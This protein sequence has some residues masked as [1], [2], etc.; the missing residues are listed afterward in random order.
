VPASY[1]KRLVARQP[2]AR[3]LRPLRTVF[4][5]PAATSEP[6][7]RPVTATARSPAPAAAAPAT[8]H[9]AAPP[10]NAPRSERQAPAP[11]PLVAQ[12]LIRPE[13]VTLRPAATPRETT[14][15]P[16]RQARPVLFAPPAP[17]PPLAP[18][19]ASVR[20][21]APRTPP[22]AAQVTPKAEIA[23]PA[24]TTR[25]VTRDEPP[26]QSLLSLEAATERTRDASPAL[27]TIPKAQ[28][29]PIAPQALKPTVAPPASTVAVGTTAPERPATRIEIGVVEVRPAPAEPRLR[30]A[31]A[32]A[33][34][35]SRGFVYPFGFRQ[36]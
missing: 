17:A 23:P 25:R 15:S 1:F 22:V 9:R 18:P 32:P 16:H 20:P 11:S 26:V 27:A 35:R 14:V 4:G 6:A 34:R 29:A 33:E 12:Q 19:A 10:S 21:S 28:P 31:A 2:A 8:P 24:A 3:S 5:A 30:R 7:T 13:D 36:G